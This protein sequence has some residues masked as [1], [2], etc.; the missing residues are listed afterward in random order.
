MLGWTQKPF[1]SRRQRGRTSAPA[2]VGPL[3]L[4]SASYS[5][6]VAVELTFSRAVEIGAIDVSAIVVDDGP[7]TGTR[8]AGDGTAT[9]V[10][11]TKVLVPLVVVGGST[12]DAIVLD[13]SAGNGIVASGDGA[14]WAGVTNFAI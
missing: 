10:S 3:T 5:P 8:Y 6:D 11:P 1:G 2:P 4:V 7:I 9:L 12:Q 14:A 13:A